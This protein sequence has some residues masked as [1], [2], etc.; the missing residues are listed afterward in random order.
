LRNLPPERLAGLAGVPGVSWVCL[1]KNAPAEGLD[2]VPPEMG[3]FDG[4]AE[5]PDFAA[6]AAAVEALDLV[7]TVDTAAAHLAGAM[8]K[9]VWI[10]SRFSGCWRWQLHRADSPWYPSARIYRQAAPGAW[11][12]VIAEVARDLETTAA[13]H[14]P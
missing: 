9:P 14:G 2:R 7:I 5:V 13:G 10:L 3:L 8:G 11:D 6:A 4:M 12:E 1:Q